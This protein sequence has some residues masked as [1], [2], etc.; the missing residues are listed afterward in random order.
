MSNV[1]KQCMRCKQIGCCNQDAKVHLAN[2]CYGEL[3]EINISCD[4]LSI[5]EDISADKNFLQAMIDLKEKDIIEYNLKMSQFR[6]QLG[7]QESSSAQNDT[8][9]RCP[10]CKS[11]NVKKISG[12]SKAGSV[13]LFGVFAAGKVSKNY[14]CN[15][16]GSDF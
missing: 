12:M 11:A 10:Y 4:E 9:L 1:V 6:T 16:C 2:S 15:Q 7:Q 3:K 8:T 14:H 13:A 5:I